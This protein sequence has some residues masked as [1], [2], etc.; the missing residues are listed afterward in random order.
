MIPILCAHCQEHIFNLEMAKLVWPF[1][2][3]MFTPAKTFN[4][5]VLPVNLI[6]T[7]CPYCEQLPFYANMEQGGLHP[8]LSA[9]GEDGRPKMI[10]GYQVTGEKQKFVPC[11]SSWQLG[12]G[13]AGKREVARKKPGRPR[14]KD[15]KG[16]PGKKG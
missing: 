2:R 12:Q 1:T 15:Q 16:K 6:D 3:D 14:K 7:W 13:K 11:P 4:D 8:R 10:Q 5:W 9:R